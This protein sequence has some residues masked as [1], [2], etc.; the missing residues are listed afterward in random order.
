M[1][2]PLD[3]LRRQGVKAE[4]IE[5]VE[6][7][8]ARH[9]DLFSQWTSMRLTPRRLRIALVDYYVEQGRQQLEARFFPK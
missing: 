1:A 9:A 2:G 5:G 4:E 6:K 3:Q 7:Y 8:R